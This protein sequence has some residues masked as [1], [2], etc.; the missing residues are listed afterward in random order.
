MANAPQALFGALCSNDFGRFLKKSAAA[1]AS[2]AHPAVERLVARDNRLGGKPRARPAP[3]GLA[4]RHPAL[5]ILNQTFNRP[6]Q[7]V[8]TIGRH[9]KGRSRC[10]P[11]LPEFRPRAGPRSDSQ[12]TSPPGCSSKSSPS[13]K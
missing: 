11:P 13:R 7:V 6:R 8:G 3:R 4:H 2:A 5:R 9:R 1:F 12:N 10:P